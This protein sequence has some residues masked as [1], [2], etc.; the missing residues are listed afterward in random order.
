M[1]SL[2]GFK[3]WWYYSLCV[4][5]RAMVEK[6]WLS[7]VFISNQTKVP[8][9]NKSF[10]LLLNDM[11]LQLQINVDIWG[12]GIG[13]ADAVS[14]N[15]WILCYEEASA[16]LRCIVASMTEWLSNAHNRWAVYQ[17]LMSGQ[18][19]VLDKK[20]GVRLVVIGLTWCQC[21]SECFLEVAVPESKESCG[22]EQLCCG[23]EAVIYGGLHVMRML[24]Q[25]NL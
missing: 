12:D 8:F 1:I 22:I 6:C 16:E 25:N 18:L 3:E 14:L 15:Q 7:M 23:I 21:F 2:Y 17:V 19:E 20:F 24:W 11:I 5:S 9:K 4:H 10:L 13:G